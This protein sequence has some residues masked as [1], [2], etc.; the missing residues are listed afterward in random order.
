MSD[1]SWTDRLLV[2]D[3]HC[4]SLILRLTRDDPV[5]L[6]N[7][8]PIYQ[9]DLPRLRAGGV[10]CLF[11]MVGDSDLAQS[12]LLVDAAHEMCRLHPSDYCLCTTASQVRAAR[13]RGQIALV[14]TIEGQKMLGEN[15]GHLR[16]LYRLGVRV[17]SI[18]HGGGGRPELQYDASFFGYVDDVSREN[19]RR[20]SKG[21]TPFARE[22][23]AEM[24]R[25][26]IAVD[27]AHIND[28]AFWQVLE[29]AECPVCY[30][31]GAC[32]AVCPHSRALTD[33]MM[34]ALAEKG[35]VM[36]IAFYRRFIDVERATLDRLCDH[37][38]HA[39]EVMGPDHVGIGSDFD[40]TTRTLWPIPADASGMN[41]VFE[42]LSARGIDDDTLRKIAGENLLSLLPQ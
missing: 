21:L 27:L 18:T 22:S 8:D 20:Q 1:T 41:G 6:S 15:V 13:Q 7:V 42:A 10:D 9:V 4:D 31:H 25:L 26:G 3:G 16:N 35:G 17:A 19:L 32:Y 36:G 28:A 38:V 5:D 14:L 11:T 40:G 34:V 23:L 33:E 12:S 24:A 2:V 39:L 37:F 29:V 30:T